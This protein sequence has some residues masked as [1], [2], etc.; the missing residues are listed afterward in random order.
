MRTNVLLVEVG[1]ELDLT[2]DDLGQPDLPG[3]WERLHRNCHEGTLRCIDP[4]HPPGA[5]PWL[6]LRQNE[7][8]TREARHISGVEHHTT[9]GE[10]SER[11][12]LKERIARAAQSAGFE[13]DIEQR[14]ENGRR[15]TAVLVRGDG[16][17]L[18]CEPQL[19]PITSQT[20]R[21]RS[22]KAADDGI[23][24]MWMTNSTTSKVIDQAPWARIDR[25][26]WHEYLND[27]ELP[28][29][30]G[31]RSLQI[32]QCSRR[33]TVCPDKKAGRR[34]RGWHGTWTDA[35]QLQRFDDL[36]VRAAARD[37]VPVNVRHS[38]TRS[39]WFWAPAA[40]LEKIEPTERGDT[41]LPLGGMI[42]QTEGSPRLREQACRY[43]QDSGHRSPRAVAGDDAEPVSV[44]L[45]E[46]AMP[47]KMV[48]LDWSGPRHW[49]AQALPCRLCRKPAN[50]RDDQARPCHKTCAEEELWRR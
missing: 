48:F 36:I 10:S 17:L 35:R 14:A 18:G 21:L 7:D 26:I 24:P 29:R 9:T 28:V 20:V 1:L 12:A 6:Y 31:V 46:S 4:E 44:S 41:N 33:G 40:D 11:K 23:T 27:T 42:V 19:S 47:L 49:A 3:L 38:A 22:R 37:L 15:R 45:T 25:K 30:G 8:G 2:R 13:A 32:E 5:P 39:V 16:M 34:C 43:G 50:T